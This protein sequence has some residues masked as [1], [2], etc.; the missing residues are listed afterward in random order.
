M[1]WLELILIVLVVSK[2]GAIGWVPKYELMWRNYM[3]LEIYMYI[4]VCVY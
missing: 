3:K 4:Y 2:D 1:K